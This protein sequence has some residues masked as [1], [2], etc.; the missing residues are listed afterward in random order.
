MKSLLSFITVIPKESKTFNYKPYV[1]PEQDQ[2]DPLSFLNPE[3]K[4]TLEKLRHFISRQQVY[5]YIIDQEVSQEAITEL[6]KLA[7]GGKWWITFIALRLYLHI[8][9]L[10]TIIA[11][12]SVTNVCRASIKCKIKG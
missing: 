3:G 10:I 6:R 11:K 12:I 1:K 7:L 8:L 9:P 4:K 2:V 5:D